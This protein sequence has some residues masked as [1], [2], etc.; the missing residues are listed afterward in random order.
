MKNTSNGG[1]VLPPLPRYGYTHDFSS[2]THPGPPNWR[3]H[4]I[5]FVTLRTK[6]GI[7]SLSDPSECFQRHHDSGCVLLVIIHFVA[8]SSRLSPFAH[9]DIG[10]RSIILKKNV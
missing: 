10:Y 1:L 5:I 9:T 2:T 4:C 6:A 8:S 7:W 3:R